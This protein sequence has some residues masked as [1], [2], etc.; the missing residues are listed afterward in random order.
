MIKALGVFRFAASIHVHGMCGLVFVND[1]HEMPKT[2][3]LENFIDTS[4]YSLAFHPRGT[5]I[6]E[7]TT[8]VYQYQTPQHTT[9]DS[10]KVN[11][12]ALSL[13]RHREI[14]RRLK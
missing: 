6:T 14:S 9:Y 1:V 13:L 8:Q 10:T 7:L 3:T 4:F 12:A 5:M 11:V 2:N